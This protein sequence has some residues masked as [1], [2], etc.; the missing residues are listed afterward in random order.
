[1]SV[2]G[3]RLNA[4]HERLIAGRPTATLELLEE[5]HGPLV[6]FLR[7]RFPQMTRDEAHDHAVDTV[8]KHIDHPDGFDRSKSSLWTYLCMVVQ[9][10]IK[11]VLSNERKR[12][13]AKEKQQYSIEQW[14]VQANNPNEAFE[15]ARDAKKIMGLHGTAI[16]KNETDKRILDL[17]LEGEKQV[18]VYA[19]AMELAPGADHAAAVKRA[20]D[21]IKA[22]LKKVYYEL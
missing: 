12:T 3:D 15:N 14:G 22:R 5:A 13:R 18:A 8:L 7:R 16:A 19:E 11:D 1:M 2:L 10:D 4:I 21:R 20:L 6:G 9:Q 17:F